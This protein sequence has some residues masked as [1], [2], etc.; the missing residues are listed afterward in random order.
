MH[1]FLA[2]GDSYTIG[3]NVDAPSRWPAQLARALRAMRVDVDDPEIVARTGWTTD[4]LAAGIDA[5]APAGSYALVTLMVGVNDQYRGRDAEQYRGAFASLLGRSVAFA[6]GEPGRVLVLSIPDWGVTPFAAG[7]DRARVAR[8]IDGF[9][10]IAR[11][12]T[13][14][15]ASRW[16]DVTP[17]SREARA[18]WVGS[19]GLHPTEAQY[20]RWVEIALDDAAA[21][22]RG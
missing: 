1:S 18:N 2:L 17:A 5:A 19:D 12:V 15:A 11:A 21:A 8:T 20:A 13:I 16:V 10:A 22:L 3:E 4:E 7:Q 14:G 9:N 6:G